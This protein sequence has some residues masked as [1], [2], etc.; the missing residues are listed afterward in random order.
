[1]GKYVGGG[2]L[3]MRAPAAAL[4]ST[5]VGTKY[6]KTEQVHPDECAGRLKDECPRPVRLKLIL[7]G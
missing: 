1:M 3:A 6:A 7:G 4:G 2:M 5:V